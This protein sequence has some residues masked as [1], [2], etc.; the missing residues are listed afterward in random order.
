MNPLKKAIK[1]LSRRKIEPY[2][3]IKIVVKVNTFLIFKRYFI[4]YKHKM[5]G[6]E[7]H[8]IPIQAFVQ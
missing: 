6:H 1:L 4:L 2:Q 8:N 5:I 7:L 3:N